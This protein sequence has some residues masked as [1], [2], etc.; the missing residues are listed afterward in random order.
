MKKKTEKKTKSIQLNR[1]QYAHIADKYYNEGKYLTAL[2]FAQREYQEY[3][4]DYETYARLCDIYEAMGLQGTAINYWYK[5]LRVAHDEDLPDIYEGL[6]ANYLSIGN[7][8]QAAYYYNKLIDVDDTL[9]EETRMDVIQAFSKEKKAGFRFVYPPEIADYSEHLNIGS[10]EFK[11]GEFDKA[12]ET[13]GEVPKGAKEFASAK[14]MQ[15]IAYLLSEDSEKAEKACLEILEENPEEIRALATLAAVYLEQG[16]QEE[17]FNIAK[18]LSVMKTDNREEGYKIATVC[19]ENGLHEQAYEW[20]TKLERETAYDGRMLYFKGVA[21]YKSGRLAEAEETLAD[22]CAV[23]PDAEVAKYYLREIR[24]YRAELEDGKKSTPPELIYLYHLPQEEREE[25]SKILLN[26]GSCPRDEAQLFGLIALHD[27]YF[28]WCF[29]E[30][31]GGDRDLQYLALVTANHVRADEFIQDVL[32]DFEVADVLKIE[33]LR[34]LLERNEELEIGVVL[35]H[36]YK[37]VKTYPIAVGRKRRKKF[38]EGY[39]RILS[40]FVMLDD[41]YARKVKRATEKLY[42]LLEENGGLDLVNN[43]DELACAIYLYAGFKELGQEHSFVATAF[44]ANVDKVHVL[45]SYTIPKLK[46]EKNEVD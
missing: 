39:A 22:L 43:P 5:L 6:A 1:K 21:A 4:G 37:L 32:L 15:A 10:K 26:I 40:K 24:R 25:R 35:C 12:I 31:D 42:A 8:R 2:R 38:I 46:G 16:R 29:D 11:T 14:E 34:M 20:F 19:C 28:T 30:M 45:L 44:N 23:Y 13:L 9:P 17:S 18:R 27:G 41:N 36:I 7:E 33:T 3:G